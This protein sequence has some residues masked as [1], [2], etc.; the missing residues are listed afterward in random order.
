MTSFFEILYTLC[1][2]IKTN[3]IYAVLY[4]FFLEFKRN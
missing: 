4:L 3:I 2:D 1:V